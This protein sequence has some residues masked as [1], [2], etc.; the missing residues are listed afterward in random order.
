MFRVSHFTFHVLR[1]SLA[2][3]FILFIYCSIFLF[4]FAY[5]FIDFKGINITPLSPITP[6]RQNTQN[7]P[8]YTATYK[9]P[10]QP[11]T[12]PSSTNPSTSQPFTKT[13]VKGFQYYN[14]KHTSLVRNYYHFVGEKKTKNNVSFVKGAWE[15]FRKLPEFSDID[16]V[17]VWSD[18][19]PKHFKLTE[20]QFYFSCISKPNFRIVSYNFFASHHGQSACDAAASTS[21]KRYNNNNN[22]NSDNNDNNNN[23]KKYNKKYNIILYKIK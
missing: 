19:G 3:I 14:T 8:T 5:V 22:N 21:K 12:T 13:Q 23:N 1:F 2:S 15:K 6:I 10:L 17:I 4:S 16:S 7:S 11:P 18:G 20:G 9:I